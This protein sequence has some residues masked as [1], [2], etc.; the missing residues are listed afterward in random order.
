M[1]TREVITK[2]KEG[3]NLLG[4]P[5]FEELENGRFKCVETGHELLDKDKSSYSQSKRC[6]LGLIDYAVSHCKPPLN[7]FKQDPL[8]RYLYYFCLYYFNKFKA[9]RFLMINYTRKPQFWLRLYR[10]YLIVLTVPS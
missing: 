3:T 1:L 6:R 2:E 9:F 4:S 8:S 7:T 10:V 5:T